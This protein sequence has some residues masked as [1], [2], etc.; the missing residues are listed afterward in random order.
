MATLDD[1]EAA[2]RTSWDRGTV[3]VYADHLQ[4]LGDTRGELIAIDLRIEEAGPTPELV[5]RREEILA[6]WLGAELP[7]GVIRHG[8]IDVDATS[9]DPAAQAR[10]AFEGPGALF[11]RSVTM[12]GPPSLLAETLGVVAAA[13]RPALTQV[14]IR[15]WPESEVRQQARRGRAPRQAAPAPAPPP[16][17]FAEATPHLMTLE[18]EGRAVLFGGHAN[19]RR[20]RVSGWQAIAF[21]GLPAL[22][23][24]DLAVHFHLDDKPRPPLDG[25]LQAQLT[26]ESLPAL[27]QLDLSRNEPGQ[28]DPH[29]LG[30]TTNVYR[31][32]RTLGLR[33]QLTKLRL[34]SL[35]SNDDLADLQFALGTMPALRELE[36]ARVR[37]QLAHLGP[38]I[39]HPTAVIRIG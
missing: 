1:L 21:D 11:I 30:G 27:T 23:E 25:Q 4:T 26:A 16:A 22:T 37:P 14:T 28:F 17:D 13:P 2:L 9:A 35:G 39:T 31:F 5:R 7:H 24:L 29:N 33:S 10:V 32:L 12:V 18:L 36:V 34:P 6:S 20:L 15:Q 3:A 8:F 19:V 38:Q